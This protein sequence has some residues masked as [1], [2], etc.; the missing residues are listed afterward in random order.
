MRVLLQRVASA[1]VEIAVF[2]EVYQSHRELLVKD[3]LLVIEGEV[4][5]DEYSGNYKMSALKITD[6]NQARERYAKRLVISLES[7]MGADGM[8]A[9]LAAA[10]TP[11]RNGGCPVWISYRNAYN[12]GSSIK[13]DL[14]LGQEW[15]VRPTDELLHRLAGLVG[16]DHVKVVYAA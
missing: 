16:E 12:N 2:A 11:F 7:R 15:R 6:I 13:A 3:K 1:R 9:D 14:P 5:L 8:V 10:L 4:S